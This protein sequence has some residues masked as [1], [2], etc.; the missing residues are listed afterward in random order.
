MTETER[1]P[2]RAKNENYAIAF[3]QEAVRQVEASRLQR[4]VRKQIGISPATMA[5]WLK[6]YGTAIYSR[7]QPGCRQHGAAIFL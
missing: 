7:M 2:C 6:Q 3:R 4:E 1:P 5:C